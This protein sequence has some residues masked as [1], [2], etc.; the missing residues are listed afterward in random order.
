MALALGIIKERLEVL[1]LHTTRVLELVDHVML[2]ARPDLLVEEGCII[3]VLQQCLDERRCIRDE[4]ELA[5][6]LELLEGVVDVDQYAI[7]PRISIDLLGGD[8]DGELLEVVVAE[9]LEG[10]IDAAEVRLYL[11]TDSLLVLTSSY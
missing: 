2:D 5:L 3:I 6:S 7:E 10:I 8:V 9:F 4:H 11:L 1:I